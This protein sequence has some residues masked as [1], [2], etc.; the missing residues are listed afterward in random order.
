MQFKTKLILFFTF[1]FALSQEA[2]SQFG[3]LYNDSIVVKKGGDS[4]KFP[5]VGGLN[6]AQFSTIDVDFD[7]NEDLFI[8]DRSTNQI[9]IFLKKFDGSDYYYEYMH[10]SRPLFPSDVR[11]RAKM[12]DY[13]NDGKKDLFTYGIGGVKVYK[14]IG[15]STD[16]LQWE[17][18]K[19]RLESQYVSSMSNLY[20]SSIDIPAYVDVDYDGDIDILTFH[21]GGER[22]EYHKNMSMETYGVPD[23]LIFELKNECWGKFIEDDS[24]NSIT[25]NST[26]G[27]CGSPN[28]TDPQKQL[29]HS[30]S[31]LLA[32]DLNND[33]VMDLILGDV[34]HYNLTALFNGG[35]APNQD[36]PMTSKDDNYPSNTTPLDLAIFPASFFE[37]IDH[38]GE[39]DLIVSTNANGGSENREGIW[40]Y[41]NIGTTDNPN[42]SYEK[43]DF[44]QGDMIENGKGSIPVIV[45]LNNDSLKDLLIAS[46]Y[47]YQDPLSKT[48]KIQYYQNTGTENE[49]E[50][51]FVSDN[52]LSLTSEGYGLRMHP[53]FG[54]LNG[55]DD[56]DMILGTESGRLHYYERTGNGANDFTLTEL[57]IKDE[58]GN[59]INVQSYASPQLF[60]LDN[61]GLLDL[62]IGKKNSGISYYRNVGSSTTPSFQLVTENLGGVDM[63]TQVYPEN[64]S[65][66]HF[67]RHNDTTHFF[68][69]NK[70]GRIYYYTDIDGNI[71]DGDT[72][73]LVSDLYANIKTDAFSAPFIDTIRNDNRY[74][75]FVGTDLGGLY[76]YVA[77]Q[78]SDP[79]L[80]TD[81]YDIQPEVKV[82]PNPSETGIFTVST[83]DQQS[84]M[85]ISVVDLLGKKIIDKKTLWGSSQLNLSKQGRGVYIVLI[86]QNGTVIQTNR[87]IVSK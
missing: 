67:L 24:N 40:F 9:R 82:Y 21:L 27:P 48:S 23:S 42:F 55:D 81:A 41:K 39:K 33:Q 46:N 66:P 36:S 12:V 78:F 14:N 71:E 49:P 4:L 25:L 64:Y 30:G 80:K 47:R 2:I 60:D 16:G 38:D 5:W 84:K 73:N 65:V 13:N 70:R 8:F 59:E 22:V 18:A 52:W 79:I 10:D 68:A 6:H 37:D 29:R 3:F 69:G 76:A 63:G 86:E 44:L 45:D 7:G 35:T 31:S 56:E 51:T 53:C 32:L 26:D 75:M 54:D 50:F 61:D 15:N 43:N 85:N 72:F 1:F 83:K 62:I 57:N 87:I 77:E 17:L 58:S 11:Y 74:D 34:S 19:N 28:I 20:V